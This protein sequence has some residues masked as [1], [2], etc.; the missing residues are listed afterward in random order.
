MAIIWQ[1]H[2]DGQHYQVRQA[3][4]TRRLITNGVF[5]SQY[6]PKHILTGSVWDLLFL[7]ALIMRE[8]PKR[9][10]VLG[11]GG[12]AVIHQL[13][14][15]LKPAHI[16]GIELSETHL[17]IAR[18]FFALKKKN[19]RLYHGD[20]KVFVQSYSGPGYDLIIDDLFR[21]ID[22]ETE[23]ALSFD[24]EWAASLSRIVSADGMLVVNFAHARQMRD[25]LAY[26][27]AMQSSFQFTTPY[28][29]NAVGAFSKQD[30]N[31]NGFQDRVAVNPTLQR[32]A[33][34]GLLR[35]KVR[36]V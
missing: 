7:P 35:Y 25:A 2:I 34:K 32:A 31:L 12:G 29:E 16:A 8:P 11:V 14:Y 17:R 28:C 13:N 27:P 18:D 30:L 36:R 9:I 5:H 15:F 33:A 3:G 1:Q 20:A 10:L 19:V 4:N 21:E 24:S 26:L 23:R 6:N 22:G